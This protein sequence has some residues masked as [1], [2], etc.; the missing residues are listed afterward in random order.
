MK[1]IIL[2]GLDIISMSD[3]HNIFSEELDFPE[4]YGR[5]LD[6]LYDCLSEVTEEVE[7]VIEEREELSENLGISFDRLCNLLVDISEEYDNISVSF[8]KR[9]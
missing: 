5:N 4:Y 2:N 1:T 6:A 3:I 8:L 9:T 7:I